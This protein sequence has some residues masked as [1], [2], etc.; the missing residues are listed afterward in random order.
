MVESNVYRTY[1]TFIDD[2]FV[3][4]RPVWDIVCF[5]G[6]YFYQFLLLIII[7]RS[8]FTHPPY[9][10]LFVLLFPILVSTQIVIFPC[11]SS[12][13]ISIHLDVFFSYSAYFLCTC[14][15]YVLKL[16]MQFD[17]AK[18]AFHVLFRVC[19]F[20][21]LACNALNHLESRWWWLFRQG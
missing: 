17:K 14:T 21:L 10:C 15:L 20:Y 19:W 4:T 3:K 7:I 9:L 2:S 16:L 5:V 8:I 12:I 6:K 1:V 11:A 13:S 18:S